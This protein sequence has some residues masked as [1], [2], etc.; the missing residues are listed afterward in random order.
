MAERRQINV[1]CC[2]AVRVLQ[3]DK[4]LYVI[5]ILRD[6]TMNWYR[7]HGSPS[8][9]AL[10]T[11]VDLACET[12]ENLPLGYWLQLRLFQ[13]SPHSLLVSEDSIETR[14]RLDSDAV[15]PCRV[16]FPHVH[17]QRRIDFPIFIDC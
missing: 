2:V 9:P 3:D 5:L 10:L 4:A 7:R 11:G 6:T 12:A 8:N 15:L 17:L 1:L 14:I 13:R 16:R